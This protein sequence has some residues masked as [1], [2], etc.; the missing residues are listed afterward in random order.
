MSKKQ[1]GKTRTVLKYFFAFLFAFLGS[2]LL[3]DLIDILIHH[4]NTE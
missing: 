4:L 2:I 3:L 1:Y